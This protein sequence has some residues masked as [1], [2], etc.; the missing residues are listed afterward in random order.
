[1]SSSMWSLSE[2]KE[3]MID[4]KHMGWSLGWDVN[5]L[6]EEELAS[7][8]YAM[9]YILNEWFSPL[10]FETLE[11]AKS[12]H[13]SETVDSLLD[14]EKLCM[15]YNH[16]LKKGYPR[17][18]SILKRRVRD[19]LLGLMLAKSHYTCEF[20][21]ALRKQGAF[22]MT[23]LRKKYYDT[24]EDIGCL[25]GFICKSKPKE[26]IV[27]FI[28]NSR[29][30]EYDVLWIKDNDLYVCSLPYTVIL[31]PGGLYDF[32]SVDEFIGVMYTTRRSLR[33]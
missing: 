21:G 30:R 1:M 4:A 3:M 12:Y 29:E 7:F 32:S 25:S 31:R 11:K 28:A 15:I 19:Y 18:Y 20:S 22:Y 24:N 16:L 26:D 14:L 33:K 2:L 10:E 8:R 27:E 9:E 23:F 13:T 6:T 17:I 5:D